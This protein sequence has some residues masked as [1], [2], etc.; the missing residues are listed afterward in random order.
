MGAGLD[1]ILLRG[2]AEC[3][4]AHGMQDVET[5][6][7]PIASQDVGGGVPFRMTDVQ[8]GAARIREHVEDVELRFGRIEILFIRIRRVK[9]LP[10]IPDGLP[11]RLDLIEWI[12]FAALAHEERIRQD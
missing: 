11:L 2:Q 5:A 4:P 9:N 12:R 7:S 6:H 1:G 8:A 3:V 10:L